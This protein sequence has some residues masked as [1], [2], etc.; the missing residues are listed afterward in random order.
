MWV[1]GAEGG[2]GGGGGLSVRR[3]IQRDG[4]GL[5]GEVND[6]GGREDEHLG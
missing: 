3:W 4:E 5:S 6:G 2:G 1:S